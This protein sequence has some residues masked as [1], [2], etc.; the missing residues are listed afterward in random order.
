MFF[1]H[2]LTKIAENKSRNKKGDRYEQI[3][4]NSK[5]LCKLNFKEL[6][7]KN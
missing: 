1:L 6:L 5:K 3:N 7:C 4:K 2:I